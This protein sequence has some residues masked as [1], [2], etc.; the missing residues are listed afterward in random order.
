[1]GRLFTREALNRLVAAACGLNDFFR[2]QHTALVSH[3]CPGIKS[4]DPDERIGDQ[5]LP[6]DHPI[7]ERV[8]RLQVMVVR[9][10]TNFVVF[11]HL[12][13]APFDSAGG[14]VPNCLE[15]AFPNQSSHP[16]H[17]QRHVLARVI[18]QASLKCFQ[19]SSNRRP[20]MPGELF[21]IDV[22]EP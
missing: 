8:D 14:N 3:V 7:A 15:A 21:L 5:A 6:L 16:A 17:S 11:Q 12:A 1:V 22:G 19:V 18:P 13:K 20:P 4:L 10:V 9:S 2:R